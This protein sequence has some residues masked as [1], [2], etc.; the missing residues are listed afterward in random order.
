MLPMKLLCYARTSEG[1]GM[2]YPLTFRSHLPSSP[3]RVSVMPRIVA[4]LSLLLISAQE[5]L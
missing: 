4:S 1:Y 3:N 2:G 5:L